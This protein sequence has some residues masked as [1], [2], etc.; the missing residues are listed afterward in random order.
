MR[1]QLKMDRKTFFSD[2]RNFKTFTHPNVSD[3]S[4]DLELISFVCNTSVKRVNVSI[5]LSMSPKKTTAYIDEKELT[6]EKKSFTEIINSILTGLFS[7][8][9]V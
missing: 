6:Y 2:V 8:I 1:Q 9:H 7:F 4:V 5:D 3:L